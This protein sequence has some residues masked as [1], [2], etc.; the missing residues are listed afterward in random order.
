MIRYNWENDQ[1]WND[2]QWVENQR[3]ERELVLIETAIGAVL[4]NLFG[5]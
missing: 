1:Q 3:H 4:L 2:R 5:F